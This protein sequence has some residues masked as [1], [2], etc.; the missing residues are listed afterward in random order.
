MQQEVAAL[1]R[2]AALGLPVYCG[3]ASKPFVAL[4]FDDGPGPFSMRTMDILRSY[5]DTAT[6]FLV[7]KELR[8]YPTLLSVPRLERRLGAVGDHTWHHLYLPGLSPSRIRSEI[9]DTQTAIAKA[10]GGPVLVFRP[11]Y[12]AHD[13]IVDRYVSS[14]GKVEIIWTVDSGDSQ[15]AGPAQVFRNVLRGLRPGSIIL[16]HENRRATLTALP[17]ILQAVRDKGL[18]T[19]TLPTLL[20]FDPPT[21]ALLSHPAGC[22][23]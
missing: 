22:P 18:Q 14:L 6:F 5:G 16:M 12:G 9:A 7:G 17:E 3:G 20:T 8:A 10:S 15:G 1:K 13:P 23:V 21:R 19:V 2:L 4:T 11:P